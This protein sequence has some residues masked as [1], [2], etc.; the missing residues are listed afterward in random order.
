MGRG[1]EGIVSF[2]ADVTEGGELWSCEVWQEDGRKRE[3]I[4]F[5]VRQRETIFSSLAFATVNW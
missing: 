1:I 5:V 4:V 3:G 2:V